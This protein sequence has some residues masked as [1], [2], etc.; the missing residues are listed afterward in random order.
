MSEHTKASIKE[1]ATTLFYANSYH[2]TSVRDIAKEADVNPALI[3]YYFGGKQALFETLVTDFFEGYV[4]TIEQA[5]KQKQTEATVVLSTMIKRVLHY[6][7]SCHWLARM[8]HR[9]MTLDS[10]LVREVMS[11]YLR[12]EQYLLEQLVSRCMEQNKVKGVPVDLVVLQLRNMMT[13]P[14]SSPQYLREL[15]LLTPADKQF[16]ER[17]VR[18]VNS[19]IAQVL[20]MPE[21]RVMMRVLS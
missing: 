20:Q 4:E 18:H 10:T 8:A 5:L 21:R 14:F 16:I 19:W 7:Q 17:Y 11:T 15:F 6:Q 1:A 2:G 13:L 9:E 3:S 12:K